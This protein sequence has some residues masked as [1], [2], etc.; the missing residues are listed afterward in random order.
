MGLMFQRLAQNYAKN[1]YF[2]TDGETTQRIINAITPCETGVMRIIDPCCGEG[3]ILAEIKHALGAQSTLAYGIEY[4]EARAWHAKQLLDQCIH[5]D[6]HDCVMGPRSYGMLLLNP[7]YGDNI[8]D[9]MDIDGKGERM[10]KVFYRM[11]HG[12]LQHGGVMALIIP[13]YS[14][15]NE[16]ATMIARHFEQVRVFM[17]PEQRFKQIVVMG[18]KR[19]AGETDS[20]VRSRLIAIGAGDLK[21]EEFPALWPHAPYVVPAT[22]QEPKLY[23]VRIDQRQLAEVISGTPS[24]WQQMGL[25]FHYEQIGHRRP[26]RQLSPW[27]LALALAAGQ[28]AGCVRS[29]DGRVFV[30]KGDTVKDKVVTQEHEFNKEGDLASTRSIHTDRFIPTIR[31]LDFTPASPSYG[32]CLTI[33]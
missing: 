5:T 4:N 13:H 20:D 9:R 23:A 21:P 24:L 17:A 25:I 1:G 8:R 18:I 3:V 33:K 27:H 19:R 12:L 7:P 15:D 14:L 10:E 11:T 2:P 32:R 29:Q 31:A 22:A 26:L 30:I 16:Y 6:I 28:V